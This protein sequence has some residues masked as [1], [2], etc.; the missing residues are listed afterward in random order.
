MNPFLTSCIT[1]WLYRTRSCPPSFRTSYGEDEQ[2]VPQPYANVTCFL[3]AVLGARGVSA[4]SSSGDT[5]VGSACQ[6]NDGKN[7]TR[8]L[9]TF[10]AA[11]PFVTSVGGTR[12]V[13]PEKAASFSSGGISDLFA[14]SSWQEAAVQDRI[15]RLG[16]RWS[17]LYNPAGRGFPDVAAQS[18]NFSVYINGH[19]QQVDGTS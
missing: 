8:F 3:F 10:P 19:I 2:E 5:G 13:Q 14:R 15:R 16:D 9:P 7:T 1:C 6:T 17:G 11:C 18:Q 4:I 12:N